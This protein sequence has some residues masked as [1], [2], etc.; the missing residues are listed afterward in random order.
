M[1]IDIKCKKAVE[2]GLRAAGGEGGSSRRRTLTCLN[3]K[4]RRDKH[5]AIS[6]ERALFECA[7]PRRTHRALWQLKSDTTRRGAVSLSLS[8][9]VRSQSPAKHVYCICFGATK[10]VYIYICERASYTQRRSRNMNEGNNFMC[11]HLYARRARFTP[12]MW[13][14]CYLI[15]A[16]LCTSMAHSS[17]SSRCFAKCIIL[18]PREI[19]CLLLVRVLSQRFTVNF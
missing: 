10:N 5:M 7:S 12:P 8:R 2:S 13:W 4:E 14:L 19:N 18:Q 9:A 15:L 3:S 17:Y 1:L 11:L 16:F 6:R